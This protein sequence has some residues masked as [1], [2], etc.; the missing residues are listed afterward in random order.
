VLTVLLLLSTIPARAQQAVPANGASVLSNPELQRE[1]TRALEDLYNMRFPEAETAARRI[2]S[3]FPDHPVGP[4]M[5]GL[6]LWWKILPNL[7]V[8][9]HSHD[10]A[11]FRAMEET[12]DHAEQIRRDGTYGYDGD[13][14]LAAAYGFRGRLHGD[15]ESWLKGAQ[16]GRRALDFVFDL[17][18]Q[19]TSNADLLFGEGVYR[20][21]AEAIPEQY[22]I[23]RPIMFFFPD[24]DKEEGKRLLRTVARR[25]TYV[26]AEAAWF[27]LQIHMTFE[28]DYERALEYATLLT[29]W[30][31]RNPLF[32]VM[33]GRVL[34]R[35]GQWDRAEAAFGGLV[36]ASGAHTPDIVSPDAMSPDTPPSAFGTVPPP[37]LSQAH[38]YL[39]RIEMTR[40]NWSAARAHFDRVPILE[41]PY[42]GHSWFKVNALLRTGMT[43]DAEGRRALAIQVYRAVES[44]P[45]RGGSRDRARD[46]RRTPYRSAT[47]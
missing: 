24:G 42:D 45:D 44:L 15:R 16:D 34:F 47:P 21:F 27:L 39:G 35:W 19:D 23:V 3:R 22:P 28:P 18:E 37:I 43:L 11:F 38:Y 2:R 13:F 20:Y 4:F 25:G 8:D 31:P 46:Y 29:T 12:I 6:I 30:Y 33:Q 32:R 10:R 41:A 14:F 26:R 1:A 5:D 40:R 36:A 17:A 9:D 7:T